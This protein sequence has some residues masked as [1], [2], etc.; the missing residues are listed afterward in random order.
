[1]N[2]IGGVLF[3]MLLLSA[4]DHWFE[5]QSDQTKD[6]NIVMCCFSAKHSPLRSKRKK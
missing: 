1:M 5:P 2:H 4:V 6:Y 3:S